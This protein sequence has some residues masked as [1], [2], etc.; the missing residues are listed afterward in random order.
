MIC[1]KCR[2]ICTICAKH[3]EPCQTRYRVH[4]YPISVYCDIEH[5]IGFDIADTRYR[6][7]ARYR[8]YPISGHAQYRVSRYWDMSRYQVLQIVP[9]IVFNITIYRYRV[10]PI[11][12]IPGPDIGFFGPRA[13]AGFPAA[14]ACSLS[15]GRA[16]SSE[17]NFIS[18]FPPQQRRG[19]PQ[20]RQRPLRRRRRWGPP[21]PPAPQS[22]FSLN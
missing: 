16:R 19:R 12:G 9:D 17:M 4:W 6:D 1:V 18:C 15:L 2:I 7:M 11:S 20:Q 3:R 10:F 14:A 22:T 5:D 21:Q 8:V 13:G